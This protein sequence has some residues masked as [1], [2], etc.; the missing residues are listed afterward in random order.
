[1]RLTTRCWLLCLFCALVALFGGTA[2]AATAITGFTIPTPAS[3]PIAGTHAPD[4]NF[5]FTELT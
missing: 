4:G 5:W 3:Q 1:M 2:S